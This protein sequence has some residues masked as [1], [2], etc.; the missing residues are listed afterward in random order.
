MSILTFSSVASADRKCGPWC[1]REWE[2]T[3]RTSGSHPRQENASVIPGTTSDNYFRFTATL[4][5]RW[6]APRTVRNHAPFRTRQ[7]N[8]SVVRRSFRRAA[9]PRC[10]TAIMA[11]TARPKIAFHLVC[12]PFRGDLGERPVDP[13]LSGKGLHQPWTR[14]PVPWLELSA[15][16]ADRRPC[17]INSRSLNRLNTGRLTSS[18]SGPS[19]SPT[20]VSNRICRHSWGISGFPGGYGGVSK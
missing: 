15:R 3:A 13:E 19:T 16:F 2:P 6:K 8:V 14:V 7:W 11:V 4:P 20:G 1:V 5:P 18:F 12:L 10:P 17:S 9:P